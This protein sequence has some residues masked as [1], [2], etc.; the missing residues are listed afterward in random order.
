MSSIKYSMKQINQLDPDKIVKSA[1][2]EVL[3]K[4]T[5]NV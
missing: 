4:L 5:K 1:E 3:Y 2:K